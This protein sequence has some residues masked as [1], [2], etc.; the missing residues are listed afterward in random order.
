MRFKRQQP[1]RM[2]RYVARQAEVAWNRRM[3]IVTCWETLFHLV[4]LM[5]V[6][7]FM[8]F[9]LG[10]SKVLEMLTALPLMGLIVLFSRSKA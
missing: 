3:L 5:S 4:L 6:L 2:N 9:I 1:A 7:G 8:A 10:P